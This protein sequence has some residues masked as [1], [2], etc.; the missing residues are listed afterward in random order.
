MTNPKLEEIFII[1]QFTDSKQRLILI[2]DETKTNVLQLIQLIEAK[3]EFLEEPI[4]TIKHLN[5]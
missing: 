4:E 1:G 2:K 5:P 3:I